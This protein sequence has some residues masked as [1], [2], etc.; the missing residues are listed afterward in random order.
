MSL[1]TAIVAMKATLGE[2]SWIEFLDDYN[3]DMLSSAPGAFILSVE[4][5]YVY[6][7]H[8][9]VDPTGSSARVAVGININQGDFSDREDLTDVTEELADFCQTIILKLRDKAVSGT[10]KSHSEMYVQNFECEFP[11]SEDLGRIG[12]II[13]IKG[14][15]P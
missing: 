3:E 7:T 1:N 11:F 13:V 4:G 12:L 15:T 14:F 8:P 5:D 2:I 10:F 9:P 6:E